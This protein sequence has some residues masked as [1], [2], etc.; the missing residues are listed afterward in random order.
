M[1]NEPLSLDDFLASRFFDVQTKKLE[2][3]EAIVAAMLRK[4]VPQN[5]KVSL[6]L[7]KVYNDTVLD[8]TLDDD[9]IAKISW[10]EA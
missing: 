1:N 2:I 4:Y 8:V 7:I 9:G 6:D 10:E 3:Y 5:K